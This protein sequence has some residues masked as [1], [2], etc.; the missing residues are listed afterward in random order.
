MASPP[1]TFSGLASGLDT[2]ALVEALIEIERLPIQRLETQKAELKTEDS[3]IQDLN[4]RLAALRD[5]AADL[6]NLNS[7]LQGPSLDEEFFRFAATS[8]DEGVLKAEVTGAPT[9]GSFDV[10]VVS[11]ATASRVVSNAR[12]D[13]GSLFGDAGDTVTIAYGGAAPI[14]VDVA[15]GGISYDALR[16]AINTHVDNDGSVQASVLDDGRGGFRL[17]IAGSSTGVANDILVTESFAGGFDLVDEGAG[18]AAAEAAL[19][20]FGVDVVRPNN[21]VSDLIDGVTIEL[22]APGTTTLTVDRDFEAMGEALQGFADAY[23]AFRD[24]FNEQSRVNE[25]TSTAGPLSGDATLAGID[26]GIRSALGAQYGADGDTFRY[27]SDLG[28]R[29]DED[30]RLNFDAAVFQT[31]IDTDDD[32][33]RQRFSD[34]AGALGTFMRPVLQ[35]GDGLVAARLTGIDSQIERIDDE[36][37]RLEVLVASRE[38]TLRRQFNQLETLLSTLQAQSGFLS[39]IGQNT[40]SGQPG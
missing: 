23:N 15:A 4:T 13:A 20:V 25:I 9:P 6:D 37:A 22:A 2:A 14:V 33:V 21:S 11:L 31:S 18:Q 29:F 38:E 19:R 30:G 39:R 34:V 32:S 1:I 5:A 26:R 16:D 17:V 35:S 27:L 3:L 24:F 28:L 36:I 40:G 12:A 7:T 8:A 10:E